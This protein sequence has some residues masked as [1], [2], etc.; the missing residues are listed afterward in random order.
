MKK[1]FVILICSIELRPQVIIFYAQCFWSSCANSSIIGFT[2]FCNKIVTSNFE[3]LVC[4][5]KNFILVLSYTQLNDGLLKAESC[6]RSR[7]YWTK[8]NV[9]SQD[10][11]LDLIA[12]KTT[13]W[14]TLRMLLVLFRNVWTRPIRADY[15]FTFSSRNFFNKIG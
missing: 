4:S 11:T 15:Y 14:I 5:G 2:I 12:Y 1:G 6:I 3:S 8:Y 13:I 9:L 7:F 10:T